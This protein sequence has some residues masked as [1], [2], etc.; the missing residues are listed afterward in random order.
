MRV[1]VDSGFWFGFIDKADCCHGI[2]LDIFE[3]IMEMNPVFLIPYPSLYE[4]LNT[5]MLKMRNR[6]NPR[7]HKFFTALKTNPKRYIR[8]FDDDYRE[9]AFENTVNDNPRGL[10]LVDN[11]IREIMSDTSQ[12]IDALITFN[13]GDFIDVCTDRG[14][15]VIDG[16]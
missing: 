2:A 11:I 3:K 16:K 1:I 7:A 8:I 15:V 4:T 6:G 12:H 13:T 9:R 10:S 14:I 5:K